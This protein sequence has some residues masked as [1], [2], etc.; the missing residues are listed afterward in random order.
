[1]SLI[2][3]NGS[4]FTEDD[5]RLLEEARIGEEAEQSA[6][7]AAAQAEA[8]N[9]AAPA[10]VAATPA[11]P[12]PAS[13]AAPAPAAT[14]PSPAAPAPAP[15]APAPEVTAPVADATPAPAPATGDVRAALR[16][17]RHEAQRLRD[18]AR[19]LAEENE[20]LK[21]L[22]PA[23]TAPK[24]DAAVVNDLKSYAPQAAEH[25][26]RLER[27]N[28]ELRTRATTAAPAPATRGFVPESFDAATQS[29]V[30]DVPEL[31]A[32]QYNPDQTAWKLA[33]RA[34]AMLSDLPAWQ[35]KTNAERYV[36]V[37]AEVKRLMGTPAASSPPAAPTPPAPPPQLTA[38]QIA[39][40]TAQPTPVTL[41][42]MRGGQPPT[43]EIPD[44]G[45]Q[46]DAGMTPEDLINSLG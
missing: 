4:E 28:A 23:A 12:A 10:P 2:T 17:S 1:M 34:D 35:G 25:L 19:A 20:R 21:K 18:D 43:T 9:T 27:E 32:M 5:L 44:F 6:D 36:A 16:A 15:A 30:D 41:G 45:R 29:E 26:E 7:L 8:N 14:A 22:V 31:L 13:T 46:L 40:A 33:K 24:L 3:T 11:T 42:D 39:A 38:A 37:V